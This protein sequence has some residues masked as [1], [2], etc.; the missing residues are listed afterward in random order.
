VAQAF[1]VSAKRRLDLCQPRKHPQEAVLIVV[2]LPG[3]IQP[4][5]KA[6]GLVGKVGWHTFR[7]SYATILKSHGEDVKTVQE[8]LRHA[9]R[10]ITLNLSAHAITDVE[11][12]AQSKV[13]RLVFQT[14]ER[15]SEKE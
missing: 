15:Q 1:P 11:R 6:V 8:L 14:G 13:A 9:N 5:L 2:H 4:A 3:L 12:S 10:S 7:N